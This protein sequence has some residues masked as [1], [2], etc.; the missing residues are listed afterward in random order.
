LTHFISGVL[1]IR[2]GLVEQIINSLYALSEHPD[3]LSGRIIS[4]M[5]GRVF[6]ADGLTVSGRDDVDEC[7]DRLLSGLQLDRDDETSTSGGTALK[8]CGSLELAQLLFVVGHVAIKQ[9]VHIE[10]V[11]SEWRRRKASKGECKWNKGFTRLMLT[12]L[13]FATTQMILCYKDNNRVTKSRHQ[14]TLWRDL[15]M[16]WT[17]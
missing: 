7:A 8:S 13:I 16:N 14:N 2:F 5:G 6:G 4:S 9:I 12:N 3:A 15:R 17:K 10:S 1:S 11:E